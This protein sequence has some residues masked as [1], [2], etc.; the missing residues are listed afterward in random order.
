MADGDIKH[1]MIVEDTAAL[2]DM[3]E[4]HLTQTGYKV[5]STISAQDAFNSLAD[6][7]PDLILLD[8]QLPD[9]NGLDVMQM[10]RDR[11]INIPV[12]VITGHGSIN[13]AVDAM[14]HGAC[15]FLV[16]PFNLERLQS[17]I[18]N[19]LNRDY[20]VTM[21]AILAG[22]QD[23]AVQKIQNNKGFDSFIGTSPIMIKLYEQIESAA[24]S[25]ATV[26]IT[27]ESGTGKEVCAETIHRHSHRAN[28]PFIPINCAAIPRDLIES[29]LFGHVKGSFTGAISDRDGAAR[30]ADGGT[31]FLDEIAEMNIDM[32]TKLLRFLQNFSFVKVGGSKME[33]TDIRVICATN[34]NPLDEIKAGRFREDL[35]YRLH[36]LP[37]YMPPLRERGEDIIDIALSFL[38]HDATEEKKNFQGFTDNAKNILRSYS[39]PGNI[40]QLQNVVRN[41]IVMN[42]GTLVTRNMLSPVLLHG[43]ENNTETLISVSPAKSVHADREIRPLAEQEREIIEHAITQC[44][45]NIPKAAAALGIAPSTIYRKK[46]TWESIDETPD[47]SQNSW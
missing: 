1:I 16:K 46:M 20:S 32:Q 44:D 18:D 22:Q 13:N 43:Q 23:D 42:D 37:I 10:L 39:W 36:V 19:E 33:T 14:R 26:F 21:P 11:N 5:T 45:G 28:K 29:E 27:G 12:I 7:K 15:D 8:L 9:I 38:R 41:V 40:R 3:Y 25:T 31:L 24:G 35:F 47:Y 17:A 34:R 4:E 2:A 30:L 6:E